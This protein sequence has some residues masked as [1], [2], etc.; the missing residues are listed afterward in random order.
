MQDRIEPSPGYKSC[1]CGSLLMPFFCPDN[2][3]MSAREYGSDFLTGLMPAW[4]CPACGFFDMVEV[5]ESRVWLSAMLYFMQSTVVAINISRE[6]TKICP[7]LGEC[8]SESEPEH[9]GNL[10]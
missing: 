4:A 5:D 10:H 8:E 3:G 9:N 1:E 6:M 2:E 7:G